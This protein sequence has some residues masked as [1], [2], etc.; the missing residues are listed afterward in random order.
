MFAN[1]V[2]EIETLYDSMKSYIDILSRPG[3]NLLEGFNS[4][5]YDISMNILSSSKGKIIFEANGRE[6]N[7][8][9]DGQMITSGDLEINYQTE[10][11][12][13]NV[14][15]LV[16]KKSIEVY[17]NDGEIYIPLKIDGRIESESISL[18]SDSPVNIQ[19]LKIR[20]LRS[21]WN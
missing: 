19:E 1:P 20:T 5:L 17:L 10:D 18:T 12:K 4:G 13:M 15:L 11:A 6:I 14:R 2:K 3:E 21:I 9:L 16:D 8:D 7:L